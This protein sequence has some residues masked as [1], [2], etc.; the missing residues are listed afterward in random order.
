[1]N[2]YFRDAFTD[3]LS[4]NLAVTAA[5]R[6]VSLSPA[7]VEWS[8]LAEPAPLI[9]RWQ[10]SMVQDR[11]I[12]GPILDVH[13]VPVDGPL[14]RA[15]ELQAL[16]SLMTRRA[17]GEEFFAETDPVEAGSDA[18]AAWAW[19]RERSGNAGVFSDRRVNE[20]RG[21]LVH[22]SGQVTAFE[23]LPTDFMGALVDRP[24]LQR[25]L[26]RLVRVASDQLPPSTTDV[27]LAASLAP[28]DHVYE[29]DPSKVGGRHQGTLRLSAGAAAV[30][31][32]VSKVPVRA[33][34]DLGGDVAAE[35]GAELL[36][37]LRSVR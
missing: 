33:I 30:M 27:A 11:S 29:G 36:D 25:R 12:Y 1:V 9:W 18:S 32:P 5:L 23:A 6:E 31:N 34:R 13:L 20:H 3:T 7:R 17:R 21:L 19:V 16:P 2:G 8:L 26:S 22:R 35:M 24:E 15:S 28:L 4:L 10:V 14:L 37:G